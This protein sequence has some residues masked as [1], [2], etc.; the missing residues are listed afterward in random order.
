M[1]DIKPSDVRDGDLLTGTLYGNPFTDWPALVPSP[2]NVYVGAPLPCRKMTAGSEWLPSVTVT[3]RKPASITPSDDV[4]DIVFDGPPSHVSGRFIEVEDADGKSIDVGEWIERPSGDWALRLTIS[5]RKPA[6][7]PGPHDA[8]NCQACRAG[9]PWFHVP[10][11]VPAPLLPWVEHPDAYWWI[12]GNRTGAI[13]HSTILTA[14]GERSH[15]AD[16]WQRVAVIPW[17][18]IED[19]RRCGRTYNND[20]PVKAILDAADEVTS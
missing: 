16:V 8:K 1:T 15:T 17:Q 2:G 20:A 13:Y 19:L 6:P 12:P 11:P 4:V 14:A 10:K 3:A 9:R 7:T 5:S 18:L